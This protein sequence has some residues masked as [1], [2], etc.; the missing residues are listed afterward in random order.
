MSQISELKP[1]GSQNISQILQETVEMTRQI[2]QCDRVIIYGAK[3]LPN[4]QAIAES[5]AQDRPSVLGQKIPAPFLTESYLEMYCYGMSLTIDDIHTAEL[6]PREIAILENLDIERVAIA[7]IHLQEKLLAFL[8]AYQYPPSQPWEINTASILAERANAVELALGKIVNENTNLKELEMLASSFNLAAKEQLFAE[9]QSEIYLQQQQPG[10]LQTIV[11]KLRSLLECDRVL[12]LGLNGAHNDGA[13]AESV[14]VGWQSILASESGSTLAYLEEDRHGKVRAWGDT[15]QKDPPTW[16]SQQLAA[17]EVQAE[18]VA[19]IAHEGKLLGLAIAHQCSSTRHWQEREIYWIASI[20]NLIGIM[21]DK[22]QTLKGN[23]KPV[24][25]VSVSAHSVS[26]QQFA[27]IIQ[28]L[29]QSLKPKE[30]LQA[31]VTEVHHILKCDRALVYALNHNS[32]GKIVAE[33]VSAGWTK[34]NGRV[35]QDPCFEA[36]YLAKYRD[37]RVRAWNDIYQAGMTNC[38]IEQLEQLE[39]K[40]NLVV[41]IINQGRLFG[42]LVAQQCSS[43]RQWAEA[44]IFWLTQVAN[45][46]GFAL[47]NAQTFNGSP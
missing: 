24:K 20:A 17:F 2:L 27:R 23:D 9:I 16:Y 12:I 29:R 38:H 25:S 15:S 11:E 47:D 44:E 46:I 4:P 41:P 13:I 6:Q 33:S 1:I 34:A 26:A 30:I 3:D 32:Y 37:G 39:V 8:V 40:A 5:V 14:A 42:L 35:I 31:G 21:L 19:P 28:K 7:P 45:Q 10:I 43:T 22:P 18:I 36:R